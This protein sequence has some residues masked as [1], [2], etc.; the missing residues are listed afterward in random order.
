MRDAV[1]TSSGPQQQHT[2]R[3]ASLI[4][5]TTTDATV[6]DRADAETSLE[7]RRKEMA[8]DLAMLDREIAAARKAEEAQEEAEMEKA[9]EWLCATNRFA[10]PE[11]RFSATRL[12][13]S[14]VFVA[15]TGNPP[16][17]YDRRW[18]REPEYREWLQTMERSLRKGEGRADGGPLGRQLHE[19]GHTTEFATAG[20]PAK[21]NDTARPPSYFTPPFCA[22]T[23]PHYSTYTQ[24]FT[25]TSL[26]NQS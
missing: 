9:A 8:H 5:S 11:N 3:S 2:V 24:H 19:F 22:Q 1:P 20:D 6:D 15:S 23:Q 21:V 7:A 16:P 12:N 17:G 18:T 4:A 25:G 10:A 26:P 13:P 14:E